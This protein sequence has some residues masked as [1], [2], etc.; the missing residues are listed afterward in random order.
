MK[1]TE[2]HLDKST[3]SLFDHI[4]A[5][6]FGRLHKL[7]ITQNSEGRFR[8]YAVAHSRFVG[9]LTEWAVFERVPPQDV[10]LEIFVRLPSPPLTE[11][12]S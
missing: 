2:K 7:D 1:L 8:I 10:D 12:H 3:D 5:K 11:I 4:R 6:T 9:Q